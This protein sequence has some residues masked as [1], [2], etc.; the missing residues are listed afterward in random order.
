[1]TMYPAASTEGTHSKR[2]PFGD[3]ETPA[4]TFPSETGVEAP[5]FALMAEYVPSS[6][7][8]TSAQA[9]HA[10]VVEMPNA[11]PVEIVGTESGSGSG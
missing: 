1:M 7:T 9:G 5:K 3:E 6:E 8:S 11:A 2:I 10:D 4:T